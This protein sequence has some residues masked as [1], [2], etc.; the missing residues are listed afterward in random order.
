MIVSSHPPAHHRKFKSSRMSRLHVYQADRGSRL[1]GRN[2]GTREQT[3]DVLRRKNGRAPSSFTQPYAFNSSAQNSFF[4]L[5][6]YTNAIHQR[7]NEDGP[8]VHKSGTI[9]RPDTRELLYRRHILPPPPTLE[10]INLTFRTPDQRAEARELLSKAPPDVTLSTTA[11]PTVLPTPLD[12]SHKD[13]GIHRAASAPIFPIQAGKYLLR[14]L[15]AAIKS[16]KAP[17]LNEVQIACE[18]LTQIT[19]PAA[20][21][22][23]AVPLLENLKTKRPSKARPPHCLRSLLRPLLFPTP[24]IHEGIPGQIGRQ[25]RHAGSDLMYRRM[26]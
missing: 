7:R 17:A 26:T 23:L 16:A 22:A 3:R 20:A 19:N 12:A 8:R 24:I 2:A 21:T 5:R 11:T 9:R 6:M 10:S 1:P 18:L 25:L 15:S 14:S 4:F 13:E